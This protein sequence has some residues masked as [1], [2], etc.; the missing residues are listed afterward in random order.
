[1][2]AICNRIVPRIVF[3]TKSTIFPCSHAFSKLMIASSSA[4]GS[5][6]SMISIISSMSLL[7]LL[8]ALGVIF[9]SSNSLKV[10]VFKGPGF[11]SIPS[12][13]KSLIQPTKNTGEYFACMYGS[14][15]CYRHTV[16]NAWDCI[17]WKN[18]CVNC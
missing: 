13:V 6:S 18:N 17:I 11:G 12:W 2:L 1:M 9:F 15:C 3:L 8:Q 16:T 7:I 10:F 4:K 14:L 5:F